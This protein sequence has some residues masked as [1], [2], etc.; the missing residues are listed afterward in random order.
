MCRRRRSTH[1]EEQKPVELG[2]DGIAVGVLRH[3]GAPGVL[4]LRQPMR[5]STE[6]HQPETR[7][8]GRVPDPD[9]GG[10]TAKGQCRRARHEPPPGQYAAARYQLPHIAAMV[11]YS[12]L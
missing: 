2:C 5:L 10:E 12:A 4:A 3:V 1:V 8:G 6:R 7:G 11:N 9:P